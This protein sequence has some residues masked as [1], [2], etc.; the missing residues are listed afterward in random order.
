MKNLLAQLAA[1]DIK[2]WLKEGRLNVS[3]P[4]GVLTPELRSQLAA[5]KAEILAFLHQQQALQPIGRSEQQGPAPLSYAQQRLWFLAQLETTGI[6]YHLATLLHL[7]GQLVIAA[8]EASLSALVARHEILRTTYTVVDG[9]PM[10]CIGAPQPVTII[11]VDLTALPTAQQL[12]AVLARIEQEQS[13][14]FDLVRGPLWR[15]VLFHLDTAQTMLAI[16]MHHLITDEWSTS[17]LVREVSALY[18]GFVTGQPA[19]LPPLPI[20][21]ADYAIWQREQLATPRQQQQLAAWCQQFQ[22][23]PAIL[24]LPTDQPRPVT[25]TLGAASVGFALDALLTARLKAIS[26]AAGTTLYTTLLAA[27]AVLL[28]RYS[29]Q[30]ELVIGSPA[31]NRERQEVEPLIGFFVNTMALRIT[32]AGNPSFRTLLADV[33][34]RVLDAVGNLNLPFEQLVEALQPDR[35]LNL[36]PLFQAMFVWQNGLTESLELPDLTIERV[37]LPT[38]TLPVDLLLIMSEEEQTRA[39]HST[40]SGWLCYSTDLFSAATVAR[41]ADHFQHLLYA[42][43]QQPDVAV[44]RLPLLPLHEQQRLLVDWNGVAN[45]TI[46]RRCLHHL[47][48]E[49]VVRTPRQRPSA[50]ARKPCVMLSSI[51]MRINW[52]TRCW[53]K[54]LGSVRGLRSVLNGRRPC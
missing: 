22:D 16:I 32:L 41:M 28:A 11:Q 4:P 25:P 18:R 44:R 35:H 26:Q 14:G 52:P 45:E 9:L 54:G 48:E 17:V 27:F 51:S 15:F 47:F 29:Q 1:H 38:I 2:L 5:H 3:A 7:R 20:Q 40:L 23:V 19:D 10:Q 49:Q 30:E 46:T 33:R 12:P 39:G 53:H 24:A 36:N 31:A 21:Y 13:R 42:L 6:T 37:A 34:Q 8:L 50:M 43:L